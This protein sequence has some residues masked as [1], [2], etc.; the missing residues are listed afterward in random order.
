MENVEN[1][2]G[3]VVNISGEVVAVDTQGTER[4]LDAGA[5]INPGDMIIVRP[6]GSAEVNLGQDETETIPS[7]TAAV[8]EIDPQ[9]GEMVLVIQSVG[10]EGLEVAD[11]QQ[12]ILAGQDPTEILEETAAGN[13]APS[14]SG[15]SDFQTV[16]RTAEEVIAQ[17]GFDTT[18]DLYAP[19]PYVED[20]ADFIAEEIPTIIFVGN[21]ETQLSSVTVPEG[22]DAIFTIN[23][24]SSS[25]SVQSYG[26]GLADGTATGGGV[27]YTDIL[28][29][30]SFSNGV[31]I[32][33][34]NVLV[35]AGVTSFTVTIPTTLDDVKEAESENF[36]LTVGGA[37]A[38]GV[39]T[40]K[41]VFEIQSVTSDTEAEGSTLVH[42]VTL[43]GSS[44][45][46]ETF[47]FSLAD[48]TTESGDWS[49]LQFSDGV[50]LNAGV[51]TVP[52]GVTSFTVST[53]AAT[54]ADVENSEF[55][56]LTVGGVAA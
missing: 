19:D 4:Q 1:T 3:M 51:I 25:N 12:A 39:I 46:D 30:S 33:G 27:D 32:V 23:L 21:P 52:A 29:D 36:V 53:D 16:G 43:S 7:D 2:K 13:T 26:I 6:N 37:S 28:T 34:D 45:N 50:T 56:D 22:T 41:S 8:L 31:T 54:D 55:Y 17:A 10:A 47:S 49:N 9:T 44:V 42:T 48:N 40:E 35:P 18:A 14:R 11:I 15:F 20:T 38:E 5:Q 24:S